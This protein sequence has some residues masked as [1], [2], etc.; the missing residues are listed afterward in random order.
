MPHTHQP[1]CP[2]NEYILYTAV[3]S[4]NLDLTVQTS[5]RGTF[6]GLVHHLLG[7]RQRRRGWTI[8]SQPRSSSRFRARREVDEDPFEVS[9]RP[10][11]QERTTSIDSE[12]GWH[13]L[14][15]RVVLARTYTHTTSMSQHHDV[16]PQVHV[17]CRFLCNHKS[18]QPQRTGGFVQVMDVFA[19]NSPFLS[20]HAA[21]CRRGPVGATDPIGC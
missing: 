15:G 20:H 8:R 11:C 6:A 21:R 5:E 16:T 3:R 1:L 18:G 4:S 2:G 12:M 9:G 13:G 10:G 17:H 7:W 14:D 19:M